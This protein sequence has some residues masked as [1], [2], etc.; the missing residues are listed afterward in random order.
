MGL[1]QQWTISSPILPVLPEA[2]EGP[3]WYALRSLARHE[4][5]VASRLQQSGVVTF[6][7]LMRKIHRWSDRNQTLD[8]PLFPGY[9]FVQIAPITA[10]YLTVLR[11][12]GVAHFVGTG[13]KPLPIPQKEIEDIRIMLHGEHPCSP[14][15]FLQEG[16]RVRIRGGCLDGVE[17]ILVTSK[18]NRSLVVSVELIQR[19]LILSLEGYEVV[20]L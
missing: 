12:P 13:K 10:D 3:C 16:Q 2:P 17:G 4:K 5:K 11:T 15:P 20:P 7:P 14:H 6:L 19:S 18:N 9:V 8:L 1:G